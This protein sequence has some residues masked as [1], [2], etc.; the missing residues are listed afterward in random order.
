M[1]CPAC[2]GVLHRV[3]YRGLVL[4]QC[5]GCRGVWYDANELAPFLEHYLADHPDLPSARLMLNQRS[6]TLVPAWEAGR[7]CPHCD[8]PMEKYNYGYD[9]GIILDRCHACKGVWVDANEV[10]Q[11]ARYVKG[12]PKLNRLAESLAAHT[13]E[14]EDF[15]QDLSIAPFALLFAWIGMAIP[16]ADDTPKKTIPIVTYAFLFANLL[17]MA[18]LYYAVDDWA[19]VFKTYGMMPANVIAGREWGTLITSM[20]LHGDLG[21]LCGNMLFLW[22]F[23][24]NVEDRLGHLRFLFFYFAAGSIAS[25]FFLLLHP[26]ST[27]PAIGA[28]GAISGVLGAYLIFF[29]RARLRLLAF[30]PPYTPQTIAAVWYVL[31]WFLFQLLYVLVE[32]QGTIGIAF[33]A[34]TGGFI[35]GV[36]F[37]LLHKPITSA[38]QPPQKPEGNLGQAPVK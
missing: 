36:I 13:R 19:Q 34:H 4:D 15:K 1:N 3:E 12:H 26:V 6:R 38:P 18:W 14:S 16:Y 10:P 31:A 27:T 17:V 32:L 28:S 22:V 25:L 30:F 20:F 21:H 29:P 9:S 35:A 7:S 23:G 24:D 33:S 37:A 11:L 8:F 2:G 5:S